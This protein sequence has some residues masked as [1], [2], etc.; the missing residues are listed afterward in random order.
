M[1]DVI[2]QPSTPAAAQS[3]LDV[4][5]KDGAWGKSLMAGDTAATAEFHNLTRMASGI[6]LPEAKNDATEA[7][8]AA[9]MNA[10]VTGDQHAVNKAVREAG[11]ENPPTADELVDY[12][13][14]LSTWLS[15]KT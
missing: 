6:G 11:G 8:V 15:P 14:A 10:A 12:R 1:T 13:S 3:R 4:L 7:A 9:F 5:V 2:E